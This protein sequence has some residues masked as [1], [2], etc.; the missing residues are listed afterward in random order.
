MPHNVVFLKSSSQN[1]TGSEDSCS[2]KTTKP[3]CLTEK[4]KQRRRHRTV[5]NTGKLGRFFFCQKTFNIKNFLLPSWDNTTTRCC[6][7]QNKASWTDNGLPQ[8]YWPVGFH[9]SLNHVRLLP[10]LLLTLRTWK[11]CILES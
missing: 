1:W 3:T 9:R 2:T 6:V 5:N 8:S 11:H 10:M 4:R 7:L